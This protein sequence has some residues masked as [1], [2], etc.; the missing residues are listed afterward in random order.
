MECNSLMFTIAQIT[1]LHITTESDP[2]RHKNNERRLREALRSIHALKPRPG[3]IVATGDLVERGEPE[4]YRE[5]GAILGGAEIPAHLGIGNHD[6]REN[7]CEG[8]PRCPV[9]ENGFV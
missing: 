9:D 2:A 3:A 1:D 5:L 4:E 6:L 7:F 8:F